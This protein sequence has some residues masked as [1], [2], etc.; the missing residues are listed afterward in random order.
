MLVDAVRKGL[1]IVNINETIGTVQQDSSTWF[2]GFNEDFFF[3]QG[4]CFYRMNKKIYLLLIIQ[5][6][7]RKYKFY[8]Q[9]LTI[10]SAINN[11]LKGAKQYKMN[12]E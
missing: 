3:K 10:M 8:K 4:A 11:M 9:N 12:K 5:Y 2:K 6:A 7:I 1:K